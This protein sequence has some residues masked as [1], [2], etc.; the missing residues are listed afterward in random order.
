MKY[1]LLIVIVFLFGLNSCSKNEVTLPPYNPELNLDGT[2]PVSNSIMKKMEGIYSLS[3]GSG[4]LGEEFVCKVSRRKVSFF[5]NQSGIFIILRYGL[6]PVDSSIQFA[7][8]WRYSENTTQ[9]NLGFSISRDSGGYE[10]LA[11]GIADSIRLQ[12]LFVDEDLYAKSLTISFKKHFSQFII[13]KESDN[14]VNNDFAVFAHH[15]VQTTSNPPYAENSINGVLNDEDY[16]VSGIEFDV[17]MT[18]DHVPI[19]I[20]DPSINT[21]LTLKGPLSGDYDQYNFSVL[22]DYIRLRDGQK[23]PS[24]EEVINTFLEST[25]MK[26]LW[27]D[28]KGNPDIFKYLEPI[29][30]AGYAKAATLNRNVVIFADLPTE[31][32][33]DQYQAWPA[34]HD[35]PTMCELTLQDVID[36]QCKYWGPRYSEGLLL[37]D[38]NR[39]HSL[40]IR[41]YSWTLNDK[42]IIRN[43]LENGQF[44]GMISDYPSYIIYDYYTMF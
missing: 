29:V 40:G 8:F 12:G 28:I 37:E 43:Y 16:G 6:N 18:K 42:N 13:D 3:D 39:A 7:G 23:I 34:Y 32:V 19:C 11:N 5:S 4:N 35:L 33:I 26:F 10:L 2:L 27:L 9:G 22:Q 36:N 21:R 1:K 31:T 15:G 24:V 20:H 14:D 38:V 25:T 41:V 30:R 44:D 17:R